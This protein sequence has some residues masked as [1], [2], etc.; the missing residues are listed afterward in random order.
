MV[1][2]TIL[3]GNDGAVSDVHFRKVLGHYCSGVVVV[4]G[5]YQGAPAGFTCQSFFSVSLSPP[6]VSFCVGRTSSSYPAIRASGAFCV[7]V[8]SAEQKALCAQFASSGEGKWR[9]ARWTSGPTGS[10]RLAGALAWVD[11]SLEREHDA[12]DHHIVLGRVIALDARD[13]APLLYFRGGHPDLTF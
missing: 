5:L 6:L 12:G 13:G 7:N 2:R 8:L 4:T 1:V 9:G 11:C 10:P 3:A